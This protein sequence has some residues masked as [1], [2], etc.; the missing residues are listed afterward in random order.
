MGKR[1]F[2]DDPERDL[3]EKRIAPDAPRDPGESP[4]KHNH[5]QRNV[6]ETEPGAKTGNA[7][8]RRRMRER[9]PDASS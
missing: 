9:P 6:P 5:Q 7:A 3:L 1:T 4:D 8:R 2:N